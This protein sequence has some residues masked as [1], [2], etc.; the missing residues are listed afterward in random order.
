MS[1]DKLKKIS[2]LITHKKSGAY[3]GCYEIDCDKCT[4]K[5]E[6]EINSTF[7][8]NLKNIQELSKSCADLNLEMKSL[9]E[10]SK[11]LDNSIS[12]PFKPSKCFCVIPC[13]F[14]I[15]SI[16]FGILFFYGKPEF[17]EYVDSKEIPKI[18]YKLAQNEVLNNSKED[19]EIYLQNDKDVVI[20]KKTDWAFCIVLCISMI[21]LSVMCVFHKYFCAIFAI[22]ERKIERL[23]EITK[24]ENYESFELTEKLEIAKIL[25]NTLAEI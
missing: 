25:S 6:K 21:C 23:K 13:V 10:N 1:F 3:I 24:A 8:E 14:F 20:E 18:R 12:K 19:I 22:K 15:L 11:K 7:E 17:S 2:V 9:S 4:K 5:I 16:I